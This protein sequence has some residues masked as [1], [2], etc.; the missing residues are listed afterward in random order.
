MFYWELDGPGV[1]RPH[2][3]PNQGHLLVGLPGMQLLDSLAID[4]NGNVCVGTI[5]NGGIT[6]ISPDGEDVR[7]VPYP[8]PLVTNIAFG[9][10]DLRTAYITLSATGRLVASTWDVPGLALQY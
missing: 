6:I 10:A 3:S 7:H 4:A 2:H 5:A 9:G 8:D 1:I